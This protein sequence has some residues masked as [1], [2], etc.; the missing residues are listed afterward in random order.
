V[1][2]ETTSENLDWH[3]LRF[4]RQHLSVTAPART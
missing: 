2:D 1:L 3:E 4:L